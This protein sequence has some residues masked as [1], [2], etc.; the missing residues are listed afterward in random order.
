MLPHAIRIYGRGMGSGNLEDVFMITIL[1]MLAKISVLIAAIGVFSA[2]VVLALGIAA[3][4]IK[5]T[6]G[7][8]SDFIR[9]KQ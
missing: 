7:A 8:V 2:L 5:L 9:Q 1:G 3:V 4:V 6:V